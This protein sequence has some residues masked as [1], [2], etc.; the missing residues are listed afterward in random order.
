MNTAHLD[1]Y[2]YSLHTTPWPLI[3]R[4]VL[5]PTKQ[6]TLGTFGVRQH[7]LFRPGRREPRVCYETANPAD[8]ANLSAIFNADWSGKS[9]Q[10][11]TLGLL[12]ISTGLKTRW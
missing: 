3:Q 5:A 2:R 11:D 7:A 1:A 12:V 8:V 10:L 6:I 4:M 9:A